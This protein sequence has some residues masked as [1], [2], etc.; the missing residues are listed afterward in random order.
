MTREE[1]IKLIEENTTAKYTRVE[2][3][4]MGISL[5]FSITETSKE[6]MLNTF[7]R[8]FDVYENNEGLF[9]VTNGTKLEKLSV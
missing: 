4:P 1:I 8:D 5:H 3:I 7:G 2:Q 9:F 6:E